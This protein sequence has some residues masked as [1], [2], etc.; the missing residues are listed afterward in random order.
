[1]VLCCCGNLWV[2][3]QVFGIKA[4][5][6]GLLPGRQTYVIDKS[7]KVGARHTNTQTLLHAC[8][9]EDLKSCCAHTV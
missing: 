5:L 1:M 9:W 4:D 7:G 6:L 8:I 3:A 2:R